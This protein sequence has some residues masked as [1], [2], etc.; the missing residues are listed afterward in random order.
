MDCSPPGSSVCGISQARILEWVAISFSRG[1]SQH[2]DWS[3]V[4]WIA[5]RLFYHLS[6]RGNHHNQKSTRNINSDIWQQASAKTCSLWDLHCVMRDLSSRCMDSQTLELSCSAA[7]GVLVLQ[8]GIQSASP[9]SQ[10]RFFTTGPSGKSWAV[11]QSYLKCCLP[12]YSLPFAPD[13]T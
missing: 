3:L 8:A 9:A 13:K 11:S 1:S 5:G 7:C 2:R 10:C 4:S 6:H 12:G